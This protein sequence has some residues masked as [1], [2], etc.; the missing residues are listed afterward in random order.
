MKKIYLHYFHTQQHLKSV[1][2]VY[3]KVMWVAMVTHEDSAATGAAE[4]RDAE[5][6]LVSAESCKVLSVGGWRT[7]RESD[8]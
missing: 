6:C 2:S 4:A 5:C 1:Q 3:V 7:A 8:D